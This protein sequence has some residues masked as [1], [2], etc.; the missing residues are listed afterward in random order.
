MANV[1][2]TPYWV[3]KETALRFMNSVK[4]IPAMSRV[5]NDEF[6]QAGAKVGSTI[7]ARLPF[8]ATVRRGQGW[9]PQALI[10]QTTPVTL[11]YQ[12][13]SDFEWS[14]AQQA[15]ELDMVRER[16]VNPCADAIAS[17]ADAQ[18]MRDIYQSF[19]NAV[20]TP[21]TTPTTNATW[22]S[23]AG[24]IFD[25]SGP[26]DDL[27]AIVDNAAMQALVNTNITT[28][29]PAQTI[30]E[31]WKKGLVSRGSLGVSEW[32]RDQNL[33]RHTT[34][35][36]TSSTPVVDTASQTGST[37]TSNG[38][39]S[40]ATALKKGDIV[41]FS[42][43]YAVNPIS[44]VSTGRLQQFTLTADASDTTGTVS[45]PIYPSIITSGPLQTV[46]ASPALNAPVYVWNTRSTTYAQ[47]ATVTPQSLLLHESAAAF[48]I[49][50]L[51]KPVGGAEYSVVRS[52]DYNLSIRF[53]Q[54]FIL[55]SDQNGNRLDILWGAAPIRRENAV[56]IAG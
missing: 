45:L 43:V 3:T 28:F 18:S 13:G 22:L 31:Q 39:A 54:Q 26:D 1:L 19:F 16:Y 29:N 51:P 23:A 46:T 21:G 36:F 4:G 24:K 5:Y 42:G 44:K 8:R 7:L 15:T 25:F 32:Y 14:S 12:S 30:S 33:P 41:E 55:N 40:G 27:V 20:G 50:D 35:S 56:R 6:V 9:Q 48:V 53:V 34:G 11:N 17:D 10:D 52:K 2:V 49:V 47:T 38:W 37:I